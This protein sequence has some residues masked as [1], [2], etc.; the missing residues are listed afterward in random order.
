MVKIVNDHFGKI[1]QTYQPCNSEIVIDENPNDHDFV[2]MTELEAYKLIR[3][4]SKKSLVHDDFPKI[5]LQ[6]F[7]AELAFPFSDIT[8][9]AMKTGIFPDAY[10]KSEIIPIP[11]ENP[12][13]TLKDLRPISKTS[14]GGKIIE[15]KMIAELDIDTKE[16][17]I[18]PTQYGN[19]KGCSTTHYLTKMMDEAFK[20]TDVGLATT[21]ITIDY[22]KAFDLVDHSVLIGKLLEL[23]VRGKLIKIII[24]F[25]SNRCHYTKINGIRSELV[26]ISCGVPQGTIGGPRFFTILIYGTKCSL[27]SNY[28]FVD[29]K[30][31]VHSYSGDPTPFLQTALDIETAET[32][33]DKMVINESKCKVITFNFSEK[34]LEPENLVL[35]GNR[36]SSCD[37][38]KLL[39]VVISKDLSWTENTSHICDKVNRKFFIL[40]KLKQFGLSEEE[41]LT[42]WKVMLRPITEY[43]A[44]LWHSGLLD[45]D[46][47][48]LEN[49]QKKA[50]GLIFGIVYHSN[51]RYYKINNQAVSYEKALEILELPTLEFRRE[52][53]T[54]KFAIDTGNNDKHT[55]FF[56]KKV[57]SRYNLRKKSNIQ[58][59]NCKTDRYFKSGIPYMSRLLNDVGFGDDK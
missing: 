56:E 16:T 48:K 52:D 30:T 39:G 17:L 23:G 20:N 7:A 42:A 19:S 4:F 9:C 2:V 24:S 54:H 14:I 38:I 29:D 40:C 27:L 28:K 53:L 36:I 5:I 13:R 41:L 22:S 45:S 21:A 1:C 43:A 37:K 58:E 55:G 33:K 18:D 11:K 32:I 25:L 49:L 15:K 8:N 51:K 10:K 26:Y 6:E 57:H 12:L 34:N 44:P 47:K 50:I 3:K 31:L 59:K 35:N 46:I